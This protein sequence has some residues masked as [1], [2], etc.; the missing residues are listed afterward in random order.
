V[1]NRLLVHDFELTHQNEVFAL[2]QKAWKNAYAGY[3]DERT[4]ET[5][6][7]SWYSRENHEGMVWN[8]KNRGY[9]FKVLKD[10]GNRIIGFVSGNAQKGV[11][12]RLYID[13]EKI[14]Q[15]LGT[16]LLGVF[17]DELKARGVAT[18]RV[19]CDRQNA[20]GIEFYKRK[21][22]RIVEEDAEDCALSLDLES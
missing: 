16:R 12:D 19:Y 3:L 18:C 1:E 13:P 21:G 8:A 20:L 5:R 17:L 4:M 15:G 22:F 11:L 6:L 10:E 7:R 2:A 14:G 9:V